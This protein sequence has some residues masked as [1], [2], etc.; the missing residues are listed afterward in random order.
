MEA[1]S[2]SRRRPIWLLLSLAIIAAAIVFAIVVASQSRPSTD[3]A[4]L[5]AE[6]VHVAATVGGR[7]VKLPVHE[8][9]LVRKGELLFQV[10]PVP[11]QLAVAQATANVEVARAALETQRR[12][13]ATQRSNSAIASA[14]SRKAETNYGLS[15]RTEGRLQPLTD[16]GYVPAQQLDQA[17]V[18]LRDAETSL[19]QSKEQA[20]A[21]QRAVDSDAGAAASV[22][23]GIAAQAI[24]QR[25]LE[26][27]TVVAPHNGRVVGL[28]VK[29]GEIVAP[30]QSLFTLIVTDEWFAIANMRETD[31][32]QITIG[33]CATVYSMIDRAKAIRGEVESI[34]WGVLPGERANVPRSVPYVASSLNWVRVAHR[35]PVRIK[36]EEPPPELMRFGASAIVKV[37]HG[38]AC[39][40]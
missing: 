30:S 37:E 20:L 23:A 15:E 31:L 17:Q 27:T 9:K 16:K 29:T 33:N 22:Q 4:N 18:A 34:G 3:D 28:A 24:A 36:L 21:A 19:R 14:Q 10:D 8:N 38:A 7:V 12:I 39:R 6:I 2:F 32:Q 13:V 25:S 35:F 26:E 40:R 1:R 5:D 11:Y